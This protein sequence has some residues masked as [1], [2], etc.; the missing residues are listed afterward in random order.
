M[1]SS[2]PMSSVLHYFPGI[3]DP[4]L[5]LRAMNECRSE[6][7]QSMDVI[8]EITE[9]RNDNTMVHRLVNR[10]FMGSSCREF[11]DKKIFFSKS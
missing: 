7:D 1:D 9:F 6:W 5:I 2:F 3:K 4:K 10:S 11:V 8:Q